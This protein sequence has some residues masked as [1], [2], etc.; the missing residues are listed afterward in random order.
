LAA[1]RLR[2]RSNFAYV[3]GEI[4]DGPTIPLCRLRYGGSASVWGFA[5]YRAS[6]DDYEDSILPS[7]SFAGSPEEALDCAC[8]LYL[9]AAD[10]WRDFPG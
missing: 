1:V 9:Q 5:I 2:F 7:G 10:L 6:H 4:T 3:D 8:G